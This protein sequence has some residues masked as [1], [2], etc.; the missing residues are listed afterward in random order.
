MKVLTTIIIAALALIQAG[1]ATDPKKELV[2]QICDFDRDRPN[3]LSSYVDASGS[4]VYGD[5]TSAAINVPQGIASVLAGTT[6][7]SVKTRP[8]PDLCTSCWW[9]GPYYA[10]GLV[11]CRTYSEEDVRGVFGLAR[12]TSMRQAKRH[13]LDNCERAAEQFADA[14]DI[15]S[16]R[17][18]CEILHSTVCY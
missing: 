2:E 16:Y 10:C 17:I 9:N 7:D 18:D 14:N 4:I 12:S 5:V 8:R 3:T 11:P 13:A 15:P 1:C 6:K